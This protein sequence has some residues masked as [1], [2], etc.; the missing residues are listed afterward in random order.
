MTLMFSYFKKQ[1]EE[2]KNDAAVRIY[3]AFIAFG[4][5][6]CFIQWRPFYIAQ[7]M[8]D[9]SQVYCWPF[10]ENCF[11]VRPF[12]AEQAHL[13]IV[14]YG[15][16]AFLGIPLF[17]FRKSCTAGYWWLILVTVL[18]TLIYVQDYALR[19]N[20]HYMLYFITFVFLFIPHKR[21]LLQIAMVLFYFW[22]S[23]LKFNMEWISGQAMHTRP[24][25][26]PWRLVP[27]ACVYAV[28]IEFLIV[29]G[30]LSVNRRIFWFALSQLVL[31]HI[32]SW[33]VV[34]YFYPTL[35]F[36]LL[37][38]FPLTVLIGHPGEPTDLL[39]S[40]FTGQQPKA[41]YLF[42][43]FFSTL[44]LIPVIMPGDEK[45]TGEGRLFALHMI[46]AK[47]K[48]QGAI[49]LKFKDGTTQEI[50]IPLKDSIKRTQCEPAMNFSLAK[51]SC[52]L[53]RNDPNFADLDIY[54]EA[55]KSTER[56][57]RPLVDVNDFCGKEL[58]YR[59]LQPNDWIIRYER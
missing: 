51:R 9:P 59:I 29:W 18:K 47:V 25:G 21:Q 53:N 34:G 55:R 38:I 43:L 15:V 45:L 1:I 22:A 3:G 19:M 26:V 58:T 36:S 56:I 11:A 40:L 31:F 23:T 32:A 10:F 42:I 50:P 2:I 39:R 48:C 20:Q 30:T 41:I 46:D 17:L 4:Y 16:I 35:M 49:T 54:Y 12:T 6:L 27:A 57:F 14:I 52:Y 44:Q 7:H 5:F 8:A 13:F 33:P 37:T 24:L 28:V